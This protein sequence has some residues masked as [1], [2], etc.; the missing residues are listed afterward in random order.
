MD[1]IR[2]KKLKLRA[3]R[4]GFREADLILGPFAAERLD[5]FDVA[6]LDEFER[7]IDEPDQD[8]YDWILER[9]AAPAE[10]DTAVLAEIRRFVAEGRATIPG[11]RPL[12][13]PEA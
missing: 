11:L 8:I 2:I 3:S 13:K 6:R 1:E 4:R 7:L 9:T 5:G 10:H 12:A